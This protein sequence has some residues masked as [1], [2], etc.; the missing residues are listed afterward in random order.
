VRN[1]VQAA[2]SSH[3]LLLWFLSRLVPYRGCDIGGE[4][5]AFLDRISYNKGA[6]DLAVPAISNPAL[7]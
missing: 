4:K 1:D 5:L 6:F 7:A 3:F 2:L